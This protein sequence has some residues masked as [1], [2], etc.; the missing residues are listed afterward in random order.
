MRWTRQCWVLAR[1]AGRVL[2]SVRD[3]TGLTQAKAAGLLG[4]A[5][6]DV[7]KLLRGHFAGY[8]YE[9]LFG[10]LNALGER[11]SIEVS[12]AKT[13]KDARLELEMTD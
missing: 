3:Q 1:D 7:S 8:I 2:R 11:V 9:R 13:R 12:E 5:Q 6:P 4:L 10:Y